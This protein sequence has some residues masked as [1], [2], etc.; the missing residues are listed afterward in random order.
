LPRLFFI[1]LDSATD[2]VG[3]SSE[4]RTTAAINK[5]ESKQQRSVD[6][7]PDFRKQAHW[8]QTYKFAHHLL[9][10]I[11]QHRHAWPPSFPKM[12]RCFAHTNSA[13]CKDSSAGTAQAHARLFRNC[14][15]FI[16]GEVRAL[17]PDLIVTQGKF[18]RE[19]IAGTF[20]RIF[21]RVG[22][23]VQAMVTVIGDFGV[24][25]AASSCSARIGC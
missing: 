23:V 14:S 25:A 12:Y 1:S 5:W 10:P 6:G 20:L 2:I 3:R 21:V 17:A 4:V 22:T 11:A 13:K 8:Y 15:Q 18:A 24:S 16:P 7:D 19:S 9:T